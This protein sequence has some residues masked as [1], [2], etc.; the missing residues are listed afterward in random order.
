MTTISVIVD[1][2]YPEVEVRQKTAGFLWVLW[3][4]LRNGNTTAKNMGI[5]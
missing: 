1:L 2:Q 3:E 5:G 4:Y